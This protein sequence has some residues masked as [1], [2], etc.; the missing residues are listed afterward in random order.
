MSITKNA[1]ESTERLA[2]RAAPQV[3]FGSVSSELHFEAAQP[4]QPGGISGP[5]GSA[6]SG[7]TRVVVEIYALGAG[8]SVVGER[9]SLLFREGALELNANGKVCVFDPFGARKAYGFVAPVESDIGAVGQALKAVDEKDPAEIGSDFF[10]HSSSSF[11][12]KTAILSLP[13]SF[14]KHSLAPR[15]AEVL[16]CTSIVDEWAPSQGLVQGALHVTNAEIVTE[17][18]VLTEGPSLSA[19]C[20]ALDSAPIAHERKGHN[21]HLPP[22]LEAY[23]VPATHPALAQPQS[24]S[25]HG[26]DISDSDH[27]DPNCRQGALIWIGSEYSRGGR[28]LTADETIELA[29]AMRLIAEAQKARVAAKGST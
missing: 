18:G 10:G 29:N 7:Q 24:V 15:I 11:G 13:A 16:G 22:A 25:L 19:I 14:G 17:A 3:L 23:A 6:G 21:A 4:S 8:V 12:V 5:V 26:L 1:A 28:W 20:H 9:S 27:T 2:G